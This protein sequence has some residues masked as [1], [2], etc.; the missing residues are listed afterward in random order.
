MNPGVC[1]ADT[2]DGRGPT[3]ATYWRLA[4]LGYLKPSEHRDDFAIHGRL[5]QQASYMAIYD[6]ASGCFFFLFSSFSVSLLSC[7]P[8]CLSALLALFACLLSPRSALLASF[9]FFSFCLSSP[10]ASFSLFSLSRS[11]FPHSLFAS[12]SS[13]SFLLSYFLRTGCCHNNKGKSTRTENRTEKII[14]NSGWVWLTGV[15]L[16][17]LKMGLNVAFLF[18]GPFQGV[19]NVPAGRSVGL[20]VYAR[21][22][23]GILELQSR[24]SPP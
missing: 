5:R 11:F 3:S 23:A 13:L 14:D 21:T 20:R 2:R 18:T 19:V 8:F 1:V 7:L 12:L 10:P 17:S 4:T 9:S 24:Y 22:P 6:G 16:A 15:N